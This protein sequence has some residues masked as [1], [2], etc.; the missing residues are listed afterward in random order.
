MRARGIGRE[1]ALSFLVSL[2]LIYVFKTYLLD[3]I[4]IKN[5]FRRQ[6]VFDPNE[7]SN[8]GEDSL[9]EV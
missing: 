6:L 4:K 7:N 8:C 5:I 3:N 1:I 2:M 9:L